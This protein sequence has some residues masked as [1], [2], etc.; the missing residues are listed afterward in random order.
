MCVLLGTA[1]GTLWHLGCDAE[2]ESALSTTSSARTTPRPTSTS[3]QLQNFHTKSN[4]LPPGGGHPRGDTTGDCKRS[5][6][7]PSRGSP[8]TATPTSSGTTSVPSA[9]QSEPTRG[10]HVPGKFAKK[11]GGR[12]LLADTCT[13]I[14]TYC[15]CVL[16]YYCQHI[17]TSVD[18]PS[19]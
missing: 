12:C 1:G 16:L 3:P 19:N 15:T 7:L 18:D 5:D 10:N 9:S 8:P 2:L 17:G 4:T 11:H 13:Y 6:T 14:P